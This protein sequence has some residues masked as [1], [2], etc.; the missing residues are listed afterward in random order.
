MTDRE[1]WGLL[2]DG[3]TDKREVSGVRSVRGVASGV[4]TP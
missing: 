4:V 1:V 3:G 2:E